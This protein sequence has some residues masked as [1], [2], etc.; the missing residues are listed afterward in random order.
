[1]GNPGLTHQGTFWDYP[2]KEQLKTYPVVAVQGS[3]SQNKS[4]AA[5]NCPNCFSVPKKLEIE[6]WNNAAKKSAHI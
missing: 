1:M 3:G 4:V 5:A 2:W 6:P